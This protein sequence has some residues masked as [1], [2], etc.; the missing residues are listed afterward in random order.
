MLGKNVRNYILM[1]TL[2]R[3]NKRIRFYFYSIHRTCGVNH[4]RVCHYRGGFFLQTGS[5]CISCKNTFFRY[6]FFRFIATNKFAGIPRNGFYGCAYRGI[7]PRYVKRYWNN[8]CRNWA[9]RLP[10][11]RTYLHVCICERVLCTS[12]A[13][14]LRRI[15]A[16]LSR[17]TLRSSFSIDHRK[18]VRESIY[19]VS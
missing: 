13:V 4:R 8:C 14:K 11:A 7:V 2:G 19:Y 10:H 5:D 17:S 16:A 1:K 12:F 6:C 18:W 3:N 15:C 9:P